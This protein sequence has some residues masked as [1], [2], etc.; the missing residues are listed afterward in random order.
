MAVNDLRGA[1]FAN[2]MMLPGDVL[3][4]SR[5]ASLSPT[6]TFSLFLAHFSYYYGT[7]LE[8]RKFLLTSLMPTFQTLR[9]SIVPPSRPPLDPVHAVAVM[10][11]RLRQFDGLVRAHGGRFIF[12]EAST[13]RS[14]D[15]SWALETAARSGVHVLVTMPAASLH[16]SDF[17]EDHEHLNESGAARY[18]AALTPLLRRSLNPK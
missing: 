9:A 18:T 14:S 2:H 5:D 4:V 6:Q 8:T 16:D 13:R 3:R 15:E 12:V 17:Q 11:D 7:R 1:F 10:A